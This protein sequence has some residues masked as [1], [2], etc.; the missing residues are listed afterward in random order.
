M[1]NYKQ[2]RDKLLKLCKNLYDEGVIS[3]DDYKKCKTSFSN[4]GSKIT[5]E[6]PEPGTSKKFSFGM[7]KNQGIND[8][9]MDLT[10]KKRMRCMLKTKF[11]FQVNQQEEDENNENG[12]QNERILCVNDENNSLFLNKLSSDDIINSDKSRN[13]LFLI[14]KKKN[15]YYTIKNEAT[16]NYIKVSNNVEFKNQLEIE[17]NNITDAAYFDLRKKG[18]YYTFESM[19]VPGHKITSGN[20]L[21]I[22]DGSRAEHNWTISILDDE[23]LDL[24][25]EFEI[26]KNS[27]NIITNVVNDVRNT[28]FN[29]YRLFALT[30][31]LMKLRKEILDRTFDENSEIFDYYST[32]TDSNGRNYNNEDIN[33]MRESNND[34]LQKYI[35]DRIDLDLTHLENEKRKMYFTEVVPKESRLDNLT[36]V[37][38]KYINNKKSQIKDINILFKSIVNKHKDI[39]VKQNVYDTKIEEHKSKSAVTDTNF[40]NINKKNKIESNKYYLL[41]LLFILLILTIPYFGY[42]LYKESTNY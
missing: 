7:S 19:I 24:N 20:A 37:L 5:G 35:I 25:D 42:R 31:F 22:T 8:F 28:K 15:G 6:Y 41:I 34:N 38:E 3:D 9:N 12:K 21:K 14:E 11:G 17:T 30:N 39:S 36:D 29:Y 13:I 32:L 40:N 1:S 26:T 16:E 4:Y 33:K 2:T 10:I 18:K 27:M 23:T